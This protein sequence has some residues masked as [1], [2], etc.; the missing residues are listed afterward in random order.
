MNIRSFAIAVSVTTVVIAACS[1]N[2]PVEDPAPVAVNVVDSQR[3]KDSLQAIQDSIAAA[4][5]QRAEDAERDRQ[6]R[7]AEA[8]S[9]LEAE[10]YFDYDESEIRSDQQALMREKAEILRASPQVQLRIEGHTDERGSTEYN[11]ALGSRRAGSVR[12]FFSGFGLPEARFATVSLG[13]EQPAEQAS[14]EQAWSRNRRA[15]FRITAGAGSINPT[16]N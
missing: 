9:V 2:Q 12:D 11:L 4:E 7:I 1:G 15:V 6:R 13:E 10:V 16:G 3:I 5:R 14:T 8:R